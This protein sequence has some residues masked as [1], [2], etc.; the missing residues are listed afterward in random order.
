M[1]LQILSSA[2]KNGETI[3]VK[4]SCD[5]ENVSPPLEWSEVPDGTKSFALIVDD[6]DAPAKTWVHWVLYNIPANQRKQDENI[7]DDKQFVTGAMHGVNDYQKH[8]YRGPCPPGGTHR[9]YFKLY[10]LDSV[11]NLTPSIT[12]HQLIDGMK[13]HIIEQAELMGKYT[14]QR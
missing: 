3:P 2:F 1:A 14:R 10:A 9:Y 4:Y 5:G 11:L 6:P 13:G 12:K 8:G 7:S